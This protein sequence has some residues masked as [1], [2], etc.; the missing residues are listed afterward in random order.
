M[1]ANLALLSVALI[2]TSM[3][4][5]CG[6]GSSS[7]GGG[8]N[9]PTLSSITVSG[10]T[11]MVSGTTGQFTATGKYSDGSSRTL[12]SSA[13]W[14]SAPTSIA[15]VDATGKVTA[16]APGPA[17]ITATLNSVSG[18]ASL[19]VDASITSIAVTP[20]PGTVSV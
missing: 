17:T 1:R 10:P 18:T 2:L 12:G 15:T 13:V 5:G 6:G 7:S 19:T 11:S 14:S 9:N 16:V 20:N 4:L 8:S 3:F